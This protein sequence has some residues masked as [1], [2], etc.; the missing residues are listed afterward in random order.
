[1]PTP[2]PAAS[3]AAGAGHSSGLSVSPSSAAAGPP[4]KP[5]LSASRSTGSL[6]QLAGV[7]ETHTKKY[8]LPSG[9]YQALKDDPS[10]ADPATL[11]AVD[12]PQVDAATDALLEAVRAQS[13]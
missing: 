11:K 2:A 8:S 7:D 13:Q 3:A 6:V 1:M 10:A 5:K 9:K 4:A 12:E